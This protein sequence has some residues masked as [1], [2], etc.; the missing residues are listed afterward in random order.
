M[1]ATHLTKSDTQVPSPYFFVCYAHANEETV[2]RDI[3]ALS[4][5][6]VNLWYDDGIQVGARWR[7][8]IA[9]ALMYS[10]GLIFMSSAESVASVHC[11]K[12][13]GFALENEKPVF[14]VK[15]DATALPPNLALYLHDGQF[16]ER[17]DVVDDYLSRLVEAL[18]ASPAPATAP[19]Q[20]PGTQSP[21]TRRGPRSPVALRWGL[22][23][24]TAVLVAA[25][26]GTAFVL[27]RDTG[28][29][30]PAAASEES[31][32]ANSDF[33]FPRVGIPPVEQLTADDAVSY[34]AR[35]AEDDLTMRMQSSVYEA[36]T[37]PSEARNQ[38]AVAVG[39]VYTVDY[40]WYR[41]VARSGS[42]YR[43]SK[44]LAETRTG[45]TVRTF[46]HDLAGNELFE[47]Q[48]QL[49]RYTEEIMWALDQGE[50]ERVDALPLDQ[51]TAWDL[52][53]AE[54]GDSAANRRRAL[55]MAPDL[56]AANSMV[57]NELF[58]SVVMQQSDNPAR[59]GAEALMLARRGRELAPFDQS[60]SAIAT[61]VELAFGDPQ[62]ALLYIERFGD[63]K[64]FS[65]RSYYDA[66]LATDQITS[67]LTHAEANPLID[68][69]VLANV[70]LANGRFAEAARLYREKI[71]SNSNFIMW[72][73][74]ANALG[75][76]GEVQ[77]GRR[78]LQRI[79]ES[80]QANPV[81]SYAVG[82]RLYWGKAGFGEMLI[83]GLHALGES[84][85]R[86]APPG[87]D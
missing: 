16:V 19:P 43:I 79:K 58:W 38:H 57:A 28:P 81:K 80:G 55:K 42:T 77:D 71:G 24:L 67:A 29:T 85:A 17:T 87:T 39:D 37:L 33:A 41:T 40:I 82:V 45:K 64:S 34:L 63:L 5:A 44:R 48:D 75:H 15:L 13:V 76:A 53:S 1:F 7:E 25:A 54:K 74:L 72:M 4:E 65:S 49:A 23:A 26:A 62:L 35:A 18:R 30:A 27:N 78:I 59:D 86:Q 50:D 66:L 68:T 84:Q 83:E 3:D 46:Q 60:A 21:D 8:S 9:Q 32:L 11:H 12:E 31:A 56:F 51:M 61:T 52:V 22:L 69:S 6:G 2:R 36:V 47:L 70:Y 10:D 20:P 14:V 73:S